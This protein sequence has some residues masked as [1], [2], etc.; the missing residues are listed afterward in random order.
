MA[1]IKKKSSPLKKKK[2]TV[3]INK[4]SK[5]Q[6]ARK[7]QKRK[8]PAVPK[9]YHSIIPYL[10]VQQASQ[11]IQFYKDVFGAKEIMKMEHPSSGK[12]THA[13]LKIGDAK[14]MLA[15]VCPQMD[16]R[17][18]QDFGGSPVGIHVYIKNVDAVVERAVSAGAK[19]LRP[20]ENMF[21]GDR[22]GALEDPYGHKWYIATHIEDVSVAKVKKRATEWYEKNQMQKEN[23]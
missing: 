19:V 18:P 7:R 22:S 14:I 8:I 17:S 13:E 15:D 1:K 12:I 5:M 16:A 3:K 23:E 21:Y 4:K 6:P 10:I 2:S 11:A 9:G 20:V